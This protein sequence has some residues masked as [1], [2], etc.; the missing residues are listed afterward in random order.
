M[1]VNFPASQTRLNLLRAFAGESQAVSRYTFAAAK[2]RQLKLNLLERAFTFTAA[3]EK[4]HAEIYW[5]LLN[6]QQ[7]ENIDINMS[8][9]I[10]N[11]QDALGILKEARH[12]EFEES[13]V[14][15]PAFASVANEE[16]F[17]QIASKF[18]QIAQIER[19][20]GERFDRFV[21]L[22]EASSLFAA[23]GETAWMCLNCGHIHTAAEAP[24]VC[25]VCNHDRGYFIRADLAPFR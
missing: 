15:Y 20:H 14:V 1:N 4:E 9:P 18:T 17:A 12:N 24:G 6:G 11:A 13:N 10:N 7:G 22:M 5:N 25:P 21:S 19:T 2:A 23:D 3:Q 8:C 16:G